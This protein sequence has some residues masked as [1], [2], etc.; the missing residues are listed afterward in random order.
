VCGS[1]KRSAPP[2]SIEGLGMPDLSD[3]LLAAG[4]QC[5]KP[6][7]GGVEVRL[8]CWKIVLSCRIAWERDMKWRRPQIIP[9]V[10]ALLLLTFY[11]L[12]KLLWKVFA[13]VLDHH[14][15]RVESPYFFP[16]CVACAIAPWLAGA[17]YVSYV[18]LNSRARR[19][20]ERD[21]DD[22]CDTKRASHDA[23]CCCRMNRKRN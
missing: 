5:C 23:S 11:G 1:L 8:R 7:S 13:Y 6:Q 12:W 17:L 10:L 22:A 2:E 20:A 19:R 21:V 4:R 15:L 9:V 3:A 14:A 16:A 18:A